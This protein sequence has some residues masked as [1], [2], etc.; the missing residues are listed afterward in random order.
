MRKYLLRF[1]GRCPFKRHVIRQDSRTIGCYL[2]DTPHSIVTSAEISWGYNGQA[3]WRLAMKI[4]N[5]MFGSD[6][7]PVT[8]PL[9]AKLVDRIIYTL[10]HNLECEITEDDIL[11]MLADI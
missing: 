5:D 11:T 8:F 2:K 9:V 1:D 10:P 3:P 7:T 4:V 6:V